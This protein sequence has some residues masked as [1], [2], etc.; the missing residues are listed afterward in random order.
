[1]TTNA[2][3]F[4]RAHVIPL[5]TKYSKAQDMHQ[6]GDFSEI[7]ST[8]LIENINQTDGPASHK[9]IVK[10]ALGGKEGP[11]ALGVNPPSP[12]ASLTPGIRV[13]ARCLLWS[14]IPVGRT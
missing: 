9:E 10:Y 2:F 11:S 13:D 1:M 7:E 12:P 14:R 3:V 5:H 6:V 4:T 8:A